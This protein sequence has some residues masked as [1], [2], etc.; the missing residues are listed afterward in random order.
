M[1]SI[2]NP[3]GNTTAPSEI[4][5]RKELHDLFDGSSQEISKKRTGLIRIMRRDASGSLIRCAC[6]D[7]ITDEPSRDHYCR[8]CLGLGF[9]WDEYKITYFK[10]DDP[11]SR[12][13]GK[14][15]DFL[16][17]IF[18]IQYDT[19]I[20]NYDH[21]I[22]IDTDAEGTPIIPYR[23]KS[24]WDIESAECFRLDNGRIE[25][26]R[27]RAKYQRDWSTYYG[28]KNRQYS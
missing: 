17:N 10:N 22:E 11:Y 25:Y 2:Y 12:E 28:V 3:Y 24:M 18:Y 15:G 7:N 26:W 8:Y 6:R 27:I 16:S 21:L 14:V 13:Q 23:Y 9:L 4:D 5:L 19:D 1:F 20:T